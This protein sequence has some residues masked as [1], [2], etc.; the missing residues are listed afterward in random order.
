ML[1]IARALKARQA[2]LQRDV[3]F[4][5]FSGEELGDLGSSAFTKKPPGGLAIA[6]IVAMLN[7]DMVGR[8]REHLQVFGAETAKEWEAL[9]PPVCARRGLLCDL[10]PGGYGASDQTPF[11]ASGVPVLH[12]FTGTHRDYH[13][14]TDD[15]ALINAAGGAAVAG[16]VADVVVAV[17]GAPRLVVQLAPAPPRMGDLRAAGASLGTVPDYVGPP[18]GQPGV[19]LA[20]VRPGGPADVAGLRRGDILIAVDGHA[21]RTVEDFM[22]A[23]GGATPGARGRVTLLR[24]GKRL[25]LPVVFGQPTRR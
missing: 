8:M 2:E 1:E 6:D 11:Y 10:A 5:G 18:Q 25:D 9:V 16:V 19:L 22:F 24:E 20:G 21:V 14:P 23:L 12:F 17:A 4:V 3:V 13:R 15:A 7:L